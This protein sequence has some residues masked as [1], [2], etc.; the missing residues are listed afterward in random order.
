[1]TPRGSPF[2]ERLRNRLLTEHISNSVFHWDLFSLK[3]DLIRMASLRGAAEA[4]DDD[5]WESDDDD[6]AP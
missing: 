3:W 6:E 4:S 1:V 5:D 2:L